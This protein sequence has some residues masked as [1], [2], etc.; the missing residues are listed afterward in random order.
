MY[1]GCGIV[2][3]V[4][5]DVRV[6]AEQTARLGLRVL[7]KGSTSGLPVQQIPS[8]QIVVDWRQLQ[9]WRISEERVPSRAVVQFRIPSFWER[10]KWY[11]LSGL[12]IIATLVAIIMLL[13]IEMYK[14]KKSDL[15]VMNLSGRLIHAGEEE[16]K[17][18]ARELHD[19][20]AQRLSLVS[21]E[22]DVLDREFADNNHSEQQGLQEPVQQLHDVITD[23]HNLSH[24]LHSNKLQHLGLEAAVKEVCRQLARQHHIEIEFSASNIPFP[25]HE[26]LALCF[27]R[28]TQEALS[29]SVKHSGSARVEVRLAACEGLLAMTLRDY[30]KGFDP[31]TSANGLGLATMRERMRLVNGRLLVN[32]RVGGGTEIAAHAR[33]DRA[34]T[35]TTAA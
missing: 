19:D 25:L 27:Y 22:L 16:R 24:Q 29:N 15:A 13:L 8:N 17:R 10:Y 31:S 18:I 2:G 5:L 11:V 28:V 26:D 14:R 7:E 4:V 1:T 33:L 3:G 20:I 30:G 6:L 32:S 23:V 21:I 34:L 9:R 12:A 35:R